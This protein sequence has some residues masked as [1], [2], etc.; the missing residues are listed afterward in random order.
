MGPFRSVYYRWSRA[1]QLFVDCRFERMSALTR[2][3]VEEQGSAVRFLDCRFEYLP[4]DAP[5]PP[6]RHPKEINPAWAE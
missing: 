2:S 3:H 6:R 4:E 5:R 1:A